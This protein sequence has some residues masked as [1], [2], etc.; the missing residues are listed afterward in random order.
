MG[1][2]IWRS[3]S[4][5]ALKLA[6]WYRI[7]QARL[8]VFVLE[9]HCPYQDLDDK[10]ACAEHVTGWVDQQL[11][12]YLRILPPGVSYPEPALGRVLTHPEFRRGGYGRDL[13]HAGIKRCIALHGEQPIRIGAQQYLERFYQS[14]GFHT[15]SPPYDEDGIAHLIMLRLA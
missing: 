2:I 8:A 10:D 1:Q 15:V 11:A 9:Q 6:D 13:M 14:F 12:A 5:S 3:S 4:F 7:S